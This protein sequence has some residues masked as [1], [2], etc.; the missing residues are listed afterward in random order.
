MNIYKYT[1]IYIIYI[2][3]YI[4][5]INKNAHGCEDTW[6]SDLSPSRGRNRRGHEWRATQQGAGSP[7]GSRLFTGA[8]R[9]ASNKK[10]VGKLWENHRKT[11]GKP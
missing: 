8:G 9:V 7:R 11:I 10:T 4:F 1:H 6:N 3:S 2:Y 5:Y